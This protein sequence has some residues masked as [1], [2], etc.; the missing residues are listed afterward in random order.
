MTFLLR[1]QDDRITLPE[2][3]HVPNGTEVRVILGSD[4]E[5]PS[6]KLTTFRG[7]G[8]RP[9]VDLHDKESV[10]KALEEDGK[11]SQLP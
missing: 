8:L 9:G 7:T 5:R 1:V 2:G 4:A 6:D 11:F 3:I 10:W